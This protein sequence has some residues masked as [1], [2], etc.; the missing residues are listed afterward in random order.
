MDHDRRR[1]RFSSLS[2]PLTPDRARR[3]GVLRCCPWRLNSLSHGPPFARA[4]AARHA[5]HANQAPPSKLSNLAPRRR[6]L[7]APAH[8]YGNVSPRCR[9]WPRCQEEAQHARL[10]PVAWEPWRVLF[11]SLWRVA[12]VASVSTPSRQEAAQVRHGMLYLAKRPG[13]RSHS[14]RRCNFQLKPW[15]ATET[16]LCGFW[17][18]GRQ[19]NRQ[20]KWFLPVRV[21][22]SGQS[23][24]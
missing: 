21:V 3:A 12:V 24:R 15:K 22:G 19:S 16:V 20:G 11:L 4:R 7:V 2:E 5:R 8:R 6:L 17:L 13:L 18:S 14:S 23:L 9:P 1:F 10:G